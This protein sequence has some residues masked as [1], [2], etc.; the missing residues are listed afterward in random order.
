MSILRKLGYL[1]HLEVAGK[2]PSEGAAT[3]E[4]DHPS[5][6]ARLKRPGS[7]LRMTD[8]SHCLQ[9]LVGYAASMTSSSYARPIGMRSSTNVPL[10]GVERMRIVPPCSSVSDLA[11]ARP[12]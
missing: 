12:R 5:R 10:P 2:R 1:R 7:R 11:M 4:A 8:T 6:L 3:A 9:L